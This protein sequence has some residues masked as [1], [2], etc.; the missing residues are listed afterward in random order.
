MITEAYYRQYTSDFNAA[1]AGDGTGFE[2]FYDKYYER[3]A[4]F[5]YIPNATKNAGK[6]V[7][8]S[9]WK[10]VHDLMLEVIRDHHTLVIGKNQVAVEA[11]IDFTCKKDLEWV[12]VKHRAGDSFRLMMAAFYDVSANDKFEYVRVYSIFHPHYQLK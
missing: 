10:H 9:F 12:G 6:E 3:N 4:T 2:A 11:P 7:T 1:C 5:E 8:V